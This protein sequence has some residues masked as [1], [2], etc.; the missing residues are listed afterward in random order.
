MPWKIKS[1]FYAYCPIPS[2]PKSG[3]ILRHVRIPVLQE[4]VVSY[5]SWH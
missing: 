3:E 1:A 2:S 4:T 5:A